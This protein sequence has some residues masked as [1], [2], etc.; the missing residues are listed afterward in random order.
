MLE[1]DGFFEDLNDN[2]IPDILEADTALDD[3]SR[4]HVGYRIRHAV[5]RARI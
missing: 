3:R 1:H 2:G 5:R 4:V